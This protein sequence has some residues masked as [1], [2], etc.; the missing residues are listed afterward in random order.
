MGS[1]EGA[2]RVVGAHEVRK[3]ARMIGRHDYPGAIHLLHIQGRPGKAIFF[4]DEV[5]RHR[6]GGMQEGATPLQ[7]WESL[8]ARTFDRYGIKIHGYSWLPNDA[9]LLLQRFA[10]PLRTFLP[11]WLGQYAWHL[12]KRGKVAP[13]Q[14]PYLS[15]CRS[16]EVTPEV[17]PYA[18][19]HVYGKAVMAGLCSSPSTYALCSY[20]LHFVDSVPRW[21]TNDEFVARVARR[22]YVGTASIKRFLAKPESRRH[23]ELFQ[24]LSSRAPRIAGESF[25]IEDSV[26]RVRHSLPAPSVSQVIAVVGNMLQRESLSLDRVL[27]TALTTW[28]ATRAG[29]ATLKQMGKLFDREP[30]TLRADIESHRK[31]RPGL[32]ELSVPEL[33]RLTHSDVTSATGGIRSAPSPGLYVST[34]PSDLLARVPASRALK[35]VRARAE[36][37]KGGD[38]HA[39]TSSGPP[40][41]TMISKQGLP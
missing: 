6:S 15:R 35:G 27:A 4:P 24:R 13:G 7:V 25:D 30:T 9:F 22:G 39:P 29:A 11:S 40:P 23:A 14:S 34:I 3:D 33:L 20:S 28:Y 21:F 2:L 1:P 32:F 18:L 8:V 31:S 38:G 36:P 37:T 10:V 16:I 5:L 19:R 41:E 12:H 26:Q 17:L